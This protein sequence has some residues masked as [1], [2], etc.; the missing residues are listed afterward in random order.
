M[1]LIKEPHVSSLFPFYNGKREASQLC[2][3]RKLYA[4]CIKWCDSA[5]GTNLGGFQNI[6]HTPVGIWI[7]GQRIKA[8]GN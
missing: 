4:M 6:L 5:Y 8:S 7:Q 3:E 1:I 2:R